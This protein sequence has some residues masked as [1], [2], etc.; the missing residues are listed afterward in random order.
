MAQRDRQGVGGVVGQRRRV[1]HRQR[2]AHHKL[3][4][5]LVGAPV[6]GHGEFHMRGRVFKKLEM[7]G[8]RG[9]QRHRAGLSQPEGALDVGGDKAPL[10][11]HRVGRILIDKFVQA[12]V[13]R[14][15]L[16][17]VN[18]VGIGPDHTGRDMV[19]RAALPFDYTETRDRPPRVYSNHPHPRPPARPRGFCPA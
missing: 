3:H 1:V 15:Q 10:Q 8:G 6:T 18:G 14:Q 9:Q 11:A 19:D 12:L 4:L 7:V 5:R 2:A 16:V 17:A 13:N